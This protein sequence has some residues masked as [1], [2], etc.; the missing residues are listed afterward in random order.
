MLWWCGR[1]SLNDVAEKSI[2]I[3]D[4]VFE[5]YA[6]CGKL[7]RLKRYLD[8]FNPFIHFVEIAFQ[9]RCTNMHGVPFS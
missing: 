3:E 1:C 6:V 2:G 8:M 9:L 7:M 5:E 4:L